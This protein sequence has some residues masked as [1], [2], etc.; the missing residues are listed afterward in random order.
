[1]PSLLFEATIKV[2]LVLLIALAVVWCLRHRSAAARH[3]VMSVSVLCALLLPVLWAV[4]PTWSVPVYFTPVEATWAVAIEAPTAEP[5][6]EPASEQSALAGNTN[7]HGELA[8]SQAGARQVGRRAGRWMGKIPGLM[9]VWATGV[10]VALL[11]LLLGLGRLAWL[12]AGATPV[13][14]GPWRDQAVDMSAHL[15]LS[16]PVQVLQSRHPTLLAT[17]GVVW[18]K[19]MLPAGA[20]A[21]PAQR[22][23]V[24]LGHELAHVRR[25][26]WAVQLCAELL[27]AILWFNPLTWIA[28]HRLRRDA[29]LACD[30]E[31]LG[32]GVT[33][34]DYAT[35]LLDLA[36][37][38]GSA[39]TL[40][41]PGVAMARPSG[42]ER[43]ITTM[44]NPAIRR[45]PLMRGSR[46]A[47]VIGALCLTV[48][49]AI[50]A[51][52]GSA[53]VAGTVV[54]PSG[55]PWANARVTLGS[56][57]QREVRM[58]AELAKAEAA[59]ERRRV[60]A[61]TNE[62]EARTTLEQAEVA[63]ERLRLQVQKDDLERAAREY[64]LQVT[65]RGGPLTVLSDE[66]GRFDFQDV[67]PGDYR[68]TV[69][70]PGFDSIE[71]EVTLRAGQRL[72][73]DFRLTIGS[74]EET[75]TVATGDPDPAVT[76]A[77]PRR[78][79]ELRAR[80]GS[81]RLQPPIKLRGLN[82]AYPEELRSTG[83]EG[84]VIL[85]TVVT[86]GGAVQVLSVLARVD[87]D[88]LT[89]VMPELVRAAVT[90]TRQ[91]Q[92][93][94]TR[95]NDVPV[96]TRMKVTVNFTDES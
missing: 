93:Q 48:P 71:D 23:R 54:D 59:F 15:G 37:A 24:V 13:T 67:P 29:E 55:R 27:R 56:A 41:S 32:L 82:P 73:H 69:R 6:S 76:S 49:L 36:R 4:G 46:V 43:R 50:L 34:P 58:R 61:R 95:L 21:W 52:S 9:M 85:E 33:G 30:D 22:M 14:T 88:L 25:A 57:A 10:G 47:I 1:M 35:Q 63:A 72:E 44:M 80:T 51:Q 45:R 3:W 92:Y 62:R 78:M 91:W 40:W 83:A 18:P 19:V 65:D 17:W 64:R 16:R 96:D 31:V 94:P 5:G 39:R 11:L 90:A 68:L 2:S 87:P 8:T 86:A 28:L 74:I 75:V 84:Q 38:L 89:P 70:L 7:G 26:D 20:L 66:A 77:D 79:A 60:E 53:T 12:R 81:G 42:F